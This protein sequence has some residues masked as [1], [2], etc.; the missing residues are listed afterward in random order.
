MT[1]TLIRKK[2]AQLTVAS[3]HQ[4]NLDGQ[5]V[6]LEAPEAR[7][8]NPGGSDRWAYAV[9]RRS[10]GSCH[11]RGRVNGRHYAG[12][13]RSRRRYTAVHSSH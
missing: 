8:D 7:D 2:D 12:R 1:A 9:I 10:A 11:N 3:D 5:I 6:D 4:L 13:R